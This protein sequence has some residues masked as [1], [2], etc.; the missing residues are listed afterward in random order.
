[1]GSF[2]KVGTALSAFGTVCF[3]K[4]GWLFGAARGLEALDLGAETRCRSFVIYE[5]T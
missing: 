2:G 1:M 4:L 5:R 3:R